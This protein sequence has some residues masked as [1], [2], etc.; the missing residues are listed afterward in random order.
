MPQILDPNQ[1]IGANNQVAVNRDRFVEHDRS[2]GG[3]HLQPDI[4]FSTGSQRDR[5]LCARGDYAGQSKQRGPGDYREGRLTL[6]ERVSAR[7]EQRSLR[8]AHSGAERSDSKMRDPT[9]PTRDCAFCQCDKYEHDGQFD[10]WGQDDCVCGHPAEVHT[11][12]RGKTL[13]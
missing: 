13:A 1:P 2:A 3:G 9:E 6:A 11:S 4:L 5:W 10:H 8:R 12:Q 7:S